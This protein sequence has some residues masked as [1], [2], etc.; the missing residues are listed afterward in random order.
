MGDRCCICNSIIYGRFYEDRWGNRCCASHN[1]NLC[2]YCGRI[3]TDGNPDTCT[4]CRTLQIVSSNKYMTRK[5]LRCVLRR[6]KKLGLDFSQSD[7][8]LKFIN[9][10]ELHRLANVPANSK[11][12]GLTVSSS[13]LMG[14]S[15]RI[16]LMDGLPVYEHIETLAHELG[17][18]W[19]ADNN[20]SLNG[21]P[22]SQVEGFCDLLAYKI[23]DFDNSRDARI[24]QESLLNNPDPVYGG[25]LREMKA[26]AD[27]LGW[28]A[29]L[30]SIAQ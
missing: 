14:V 3:I 6:L 16:Y 5:T 12:E 20:S 26:R 4:A 27:I 29:F 2:R 15:S 19:L 30:A 13:T 7:L 23:L 9:E 18:V 24:E 17:H 8:K 11:V 25:G 22:L 28:E 10:H 1:V 21:G